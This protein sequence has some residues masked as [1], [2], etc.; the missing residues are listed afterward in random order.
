MCFRPSIF[1]GFI[2]LATAL[3]GTTACSSLTDAHT[4]KQ[5]MMNHYLAGN[6]GQVRNVLDDRLR[7]STWYNSSTVGTGDEVMWRLEA[8]TMCFLL[9]ADEE[10]IRHFEAAEERI[11]DF[12]S[13]ATVN[14][15]EAGAE[16]AVLVTNL[17]A[18]PYRGCCRDR[19]L[20]PVFKAFAYLGKKD[21]EGFRV[22]L[23][24]L[25]EN[26]E[27]VLED[28]RKFFEEEERALKKAK[29]S[30]REAA[31]GIRADKIFSRP[32]NKQTR[33]ALKETGTVSR[34]GYGNFMNPFAI[35]LSGYGY[36]RDG[37]FQNAIVDFKRLRRAVPESLLAKQLHAFSLIRAGRSV[38][39]D[40]KDVV[41][42]SFSLDKG[43]ALVVFANGRSASL[44]QVSLYLPVIFP[45]YA[46]VAAVA[47]PVCEYYSAPY[48]GMTV[49]AGGKE[50]GSEILADLDG[51]MAQEYE[52]R[53]PGLIART[54]LSTAVKEFGSYAATR[55]AAKADQWAGVAVGVTTTLY[56]M[57]VN[58]ADTRSWEILPHDFRVALCPLPEDRTLVI[59]PEGGSAPIEARIP[60]DAE[61]AIVYINAPSRQSTP[62]CRIFPLHSH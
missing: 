30:N 18:L 17:N 54:V 59:T 44:R 38:P 60:S 14:L 6:Y 13:R 2:L 42:P 29:R 49:R 58:T 7:P 19:I 56:K 9:G 12:D 45:G 34:R 15:R 21:E 53:L 26:Q 41:L 4:A 25:R 35:F 16:T 47:W 51:I 37:D 46:S 40:L 23:F 39:D 55:A 48:S 22:E 3:L 10:G 27:K 36:L 24:R 43:T 1:C 20:L 50:Y 32:D 31:R 52:E 57:A 11:E 62:L 28:Y 61:S 33:E 5:E 8:G